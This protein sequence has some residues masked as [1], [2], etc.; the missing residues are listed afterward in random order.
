MDTHSGK[1]FP[2]SF[3]NQRR[4]RFVFICLVCCLGPLSINFAASGDSAQGSVSIAST[5]EVLEAVEAA[6]TLRT[7]P[8]SVVST[9]ANPSLAGPADYF[10]CGS[11]DNPAHANPFGNCFYGDSA[12]KRLIVIYGDSHA[13]M[14]AASVELV[15][16]REGW[17]LKVFGLGGCPVVDLNFYSY[18]TNSPDTECA[19]Y[20][21]TAVAAI[22]ALHPQVVLVTSF[23][24]QEI[25]VNVYP[26]AKQWT[27]GMAKTIDSLKES[28]TH[29]GVIGNIPNWSTNDANCLAAHLSN[30]QFCSASASIGIPSTITAEAAAAKVTGV[31]YIRT[32]SWICAKKCEPVI[33][34]M[35]VF[36]NEYH[37]T[38]AYAKYLS[39][40][41]Q[42]ALA[43]ILDAA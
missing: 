34:N 35:L 18:Q 23:S 25:G 7:V 14:W 2:G 30:V 39:G 8:P 9:L 22:R 29:L 12:S 24:D 33:N 5:A 13:A 27:D 43:L 36:Y 16:Q 19:L 42:S 21:R 3:H 6:Q 31:P 37:I 26:S 32:T 17:R 20:H 10:D 40:A 4:P 1:I 15:A 38:E 28:G 41:M 11:V